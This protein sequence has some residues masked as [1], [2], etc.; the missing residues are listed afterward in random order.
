MYIFAVYHKPESN[1]YILLFVGHCV[2]YLLKATAKSMSITLQAKE[3]DKK[4]ETDICTPII[5]R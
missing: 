5:L 3:L 2:D 4:V 1:E